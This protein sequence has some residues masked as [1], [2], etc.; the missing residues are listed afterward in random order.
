MP[1]NQQ[2]EKERIHYSFMATMNNTIDDSTTLSMLQTENEIERTKLHYHNLIPLPRQ[3]SKRPQAR[4]QNGES[5]M[6]MRE[7]ICAENFFT[8]KLF[9]LDLMPA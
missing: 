8:D 9:D 6:N 4:R 7:K 1:T 5:N 2:R 3:N